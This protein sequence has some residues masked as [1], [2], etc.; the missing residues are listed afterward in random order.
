M[1]HINVILVQ[2]ELFGIGFGIEKWWFVNFVD[3][4]KRRKQNVAIP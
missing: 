1:R 4:L 3:L 2:V